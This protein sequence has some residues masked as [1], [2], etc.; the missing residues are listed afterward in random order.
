VITLRNTVIAFFL[1]LAAV[2]VT[3]TDGGGGSSS[4]SSSSTTVR[5]TISPQRVTKSD[6]R[7]VAAGQFRCDSPGPDGL[8]FTAHLQRNDG[9]EWTTISGQAFVSNMANTTRDRSTADR[10]RSVSVQCSA[11]TFRTWVEASIYDN[12]ATRKLSEYGAE[13]KNPCG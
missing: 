10:T 7:I 9:G 12:K 11:G 5:C 4:A 13:R 6:N 3:K 1:I 8:T 2:V